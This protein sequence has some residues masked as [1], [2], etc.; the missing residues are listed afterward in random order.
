MLDIDGDGTR[1]LLVLNYKTAMRSYC[2]RS[3]PP[4]RDRAS[5]VFGVDPADDEAVAGLL[6]RGGPASGKWSR[7][8]YV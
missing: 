2:L 5:E 4:M 6:E 3:P 1:D 8:D 7:S